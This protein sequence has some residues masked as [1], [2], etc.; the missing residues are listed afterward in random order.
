MAMSK[1]RVTRTTAQT[2][3][4]YMTVGKLRMLALEGRTVTFRYEQRSLSGILITSGLCLSIAHQYCGD[5]NQKLLHDI[6]PLKE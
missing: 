3:S 1:V 5:E 4:I 6:I 2:G